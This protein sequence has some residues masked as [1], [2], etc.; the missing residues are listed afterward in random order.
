M[1][2]TYE[3]NYDYEVT[4]SKK[5]SR[6]TANTGSRTQR[7][8]GQQPNYGIPHAALSRSGIMDPLANL[9]H[10][11]IWN[12]LYDPLNT[13]KTQNDAEVQVC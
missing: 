10:D 2:T 1:G 6:S 4:D 3:Y 8:V 13:D 5:Q 7:P 11:R 12:K 9:Q